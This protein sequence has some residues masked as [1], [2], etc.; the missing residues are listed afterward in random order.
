MSKKVIGKQCVFARH[1]KKTS[2]REDAVLVREKIF[3][4][5][6]TSEPSL[7]MI[8]NPKR[9]FYVTKKIYQNHKQKKTGEHLSK[10]D[11]FSC[12]DSDLPKEVG[13]ALGDPHNPRGMMAHKMSPYLYYTDYTVSNLIKRSYIDK[14]PN[15][16]NKFLDVCSFDIETETEKY[17]KE[18][19][20]KD[21]SYESPEKIHIITMSMG[22]RNYIGVTEEYL[23][24]V[25]DPEAEYRRIAKKSLSHCADTDKIDYNIYPT[26]KNLLI[27][28]FRVLHNW[29]PDVVSIWG[30]LFDLPYI[31][32]RCEELG[33]PAKQLYRNPSLPRKYAEH[34]FKE[35]A[36]KKYNDDGTVKRP[37]KFEERWHVLYTAAGF[38]VTDAMCDYKLIRT[39]SKQLPSHGLDAVLK[40]HDLG[41][42]LKLSDKKVDLLTGGKWH[43]YMRLNEQSNYAVYATYDTLGM[44]LLDNKTMDLKL[45]LPSLIEECEWSVA[46]SSTRRVAIEYRKHAMEQ[47]IVPA[48]RFNYYPKDKAKLT[49]EQ[50]YELGIDADVLD[51]DGWI[52]TLRNFMLANNGLRCIEGMPE[53]VTRIYLGV[54][55]IDI[56]SSYPSVNSALN[57]SKETT[58][59]EIISIEGILESVFRANNMMLSTG[60]DKVR[61][62]EE[63]FGLA[64]LTELEE[65]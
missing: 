15:F 6:G 4:E 50:Q 5:D 43:D 28:T 16:A 46:N 51:G 31:Q 59:K 62:A 48:T 23:K 30:M 21:P 25:E 47:N 1:F 63:M 49:Y 56:L 2:Y 27:E 37:L 11:L 10:L 54:C 42:K 58:M 33:I 12:T 18:R 38:E 7:K 65:I 26:E 52:L 64:S 8:Y 55:D 45:T 20:A 19:A 34:W 24:G 17:D 3:F 57:V 35:G 22:D 32:R 44:N 36:D 29:N 13:K 60:T 14:W 39:G 9:S 41:G 61:Y 40:I 53:A